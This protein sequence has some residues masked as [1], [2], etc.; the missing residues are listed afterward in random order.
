LKH[1]TLWVKMKNNM[2]SERSQMQDTMYCIIPFIYEMSRKGQCM[3]GESRLV[4]SEEQRGGQG[5]TEMGMKGSYE[6]NKDAL[7]LICGDGRTIQ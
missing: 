6:G 3:N 2:L 5:S 4:V 7:K 1:A